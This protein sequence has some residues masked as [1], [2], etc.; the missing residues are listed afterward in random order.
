MKCEREEEE[1]EF[2][3]TEKNERHEKSEKARN[4]FIEDLLLEANTQMI[5]AKRRTKCLKFIVAL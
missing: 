5:K 4:T 3:L 1:E 2:S